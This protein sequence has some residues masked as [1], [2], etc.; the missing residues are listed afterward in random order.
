MAPE[1]LD[2]LERDAGDQGHADDPADDQRPPGQ[3]PER[4]EDEYRDDHDDQQEAGPA[5]GVQPREALGVLGRKRQPCL[6]TGDRLV[7][8]TVVGDDSPYVF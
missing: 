8:G 5:A 4:G 6:I 3:E 2:D 7:L 1:V